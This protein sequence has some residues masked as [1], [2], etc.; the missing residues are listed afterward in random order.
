[1]TSDAAY[2]LIEVGDG[3][4]SVHEAGTT[5]VV[6]TL[7]KDADGYRL[8]DAEDADLGTFVTLEEAVARLSDGH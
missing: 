1:V 5:R 3:H 4:W 2:D 6:G 8:L 7:Q